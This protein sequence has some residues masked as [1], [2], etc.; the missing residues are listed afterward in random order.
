MSSSA[1][2]YR[3]PV[4]R[5]EDDELAHNLKEVATLEAQIEAAKQ[6][7]A[8]CSDFNLF[9]AFKV[10]DSNNNGHLEFHE[11]RHALND[12]GIYPTVDDLDLLFKRYDTSK[13]GRLQFNEFSNAIL[14]RDSYHH[15]WLTEEA[16]TTSASLP[17]EE[18]TTAS[19]QE[20][21]TNSRTF[22]ECTSE[23]KPRL[24]TSDKDKQEDSIST[25]MTL[26]MHATRTTTELLPDTKLTT[27]LNPKASGLAITS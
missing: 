25:F 18:E 12:L 16:A 20:P 27:F 14:A 2:K 15:I 6:S 5:I 22:S 4:Q 17:M 26:L 23:T 11:V 9:D 21:E 3:S 1:K 10:F 8:L 19:C 7:L 13:D 24:S